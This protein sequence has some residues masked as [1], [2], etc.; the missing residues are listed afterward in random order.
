VDGLGRGK[1]LSVA[2]EITDMN[3]EGLKE[4]SLQSDR[5]RQFEEMIFQT[6]FAD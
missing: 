1:A 2:W 5:A 6:I 3:P 4:K